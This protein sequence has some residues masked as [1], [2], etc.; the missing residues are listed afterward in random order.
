MD[1]SLKYVRDARLAEENN[2][3][4][5]DYPSNAFKRGEGIMDDE[6]VKKLE[7]E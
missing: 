5:L 1:T 7:W 6:L 2:V 4:W 3:M